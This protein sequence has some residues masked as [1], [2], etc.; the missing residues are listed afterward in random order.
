MRAIVLTL[1]MG[2]GRSCSVIPQPAEKVLERRRDGLQHPRENVEE[3]P[4]APLAT[5]AAAA[6]VD[7]VPILLAA[8]AVLVPIV[9]D[10]PLLLRV[11][12][13]H[14]DLWVNSSLARLSRFTSTPLNSQALVFFSRLTRKLCRISFHPSLVRGNW[15]WAGPGRPRVERN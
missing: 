11:R 7:P 5:A 4:R 10:L 2:A 8:L 12:V 14:D 15:D 1:G 13:V 3:A 6:A 9:F